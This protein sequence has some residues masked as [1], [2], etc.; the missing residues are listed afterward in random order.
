METGIITFDEPFTLE[1]GKIY[2][3]E[4][5]TGS[6]PQ[7]HHTDELEVASGAGTIT[8]EEFTDANGKIYNDWI[9]AIK[10]GG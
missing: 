3:Y 8:C 2:N 7:I 9:P 5:R 6:Y 1:A 10:L 4:I